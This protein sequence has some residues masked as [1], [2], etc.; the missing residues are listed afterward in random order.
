M[1]RRQQPSQITFGR[2]SPDGRSILF[3]RGMRSASLAADGNS[4]YVL[5]VETGRLLQPADAALLNERYYS[6]APDSSA[7][8]I[9]AGGGRSAQINK[10]LNILDVATGKVS[11]VIS[12]TEQIPGIVDWSPVSDLIAYAAVPAEQ[13]GEEYWSLMTFENPAIAARRVYLLNPTTGEYRRLNAVEAYQDTPTWSADGETLYYVQKDGD[14]LVLMAADPETG[15][16]EPIEA[17]RRP[18][19]ESVGYYGQSEWHELF[20]IPPEA[21]E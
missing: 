17:S 21:S 19:P 14:E 3:W 9:T 10:W 12:K 1:S 16:A 15:E 18:A 2:W 6:W 20:E 5:D 11:T 8:A 7:L 13:T 4:P